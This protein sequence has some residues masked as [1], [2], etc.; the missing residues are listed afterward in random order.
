M[1]ARHLER[2]AACSAFAATV[3]SFT[4]ELRAT[5]LAEPQANNCGGFTAVDQRQGALGRLPRLSRPRTLRMPL[6]AATAAAASM[7]ITSVVV[8]SQSTEGVAAR[9]PGVLVVY[10]SAED[11]SA[12]LRGLRDI[13]HARQ[14]EAESSLSTR[15]GI[16]A[17]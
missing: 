5:P 15:P 3:A 4:A 10:A 1:L 14:P 6:V 11:D 16:L 2:C 9:S 7:L 12:M 13:S 8:N 17:G